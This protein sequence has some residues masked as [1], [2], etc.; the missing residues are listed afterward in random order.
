MVCLVHC[1]AVLRCLVAHEYSMRQRVREWGS[2]LPGTSGLVYRDP[3]GEKAATSG[4]KEGRKGENANKK[5]RE[6]KKKPSSNQQA[7]A[8]YG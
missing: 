1:C 5:R 3:H 8:L 7:C 2:V 4:G 6:E